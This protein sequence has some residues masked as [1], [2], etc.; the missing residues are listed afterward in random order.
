MWSDTLLAF[1]AKM[2]EYN[3]GIVY[4]LLLFTAIIVLYSI[5]VYFF[6]K[7][8][9]K[10]DIIELNLNQY[11]NFSNEGTVKFFGFIFYILEYIII[12]PILT[13][14]WF[15]VLAI[16]LLVLAKSISVANVM[17]IAASLVA[18]VRITAYV[19]E[20]LSRE[21][22]KMVP[23]TLLALAIMGDNLLSIE[24]L[25]TRLIEIPS[26]LTNLPYYLV[27]IILVE[28]IMRLIEITEKF[29]WP[30]RTDEED[31]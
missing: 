13:I 30:D 2:I 3:P 19:S 9:A 23:F 7:Y 18:S 10:R 5:F 4:R 16:L 1:S 31:N 26:V 11:N 22:A 20:K 6:Y 25:V 8:L 27:F 15:G 28:L 12:L 17:I 21:L 14:F 24:N 29:F